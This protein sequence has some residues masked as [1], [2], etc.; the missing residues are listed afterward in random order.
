MYTIHKLRPLATHF[1][2]QIIDPAQLHWATSHF[3]SLVKSALSYCLATLQ[4]IS[5]VHSAFYSNSALLEDQPTSLKGFV[6]WV[7]SAPNA[8]T[9]LAWQIPYPNGETHLAW[10]ILYPNLNMVTFDL[11][12]YDVCYMELSKYVCPVHVFG[13]LQ[14]IVKGQ[15]RLTF[16][17]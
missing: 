12:G 9:H 1:W 6:W 16:A 4:H 8:E 7:P 13:M 3:D 2:W 5:C 10:Q 14:R 17:R 11:P 15:T